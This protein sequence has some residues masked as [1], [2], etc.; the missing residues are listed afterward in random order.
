MATPKKKDRR[1]DNPGRPSTGLDVVTQIRLTP[2]LLDAMRARAERE[3]LTQ[4]EAWRRAATAWL[5]A[6]P[7]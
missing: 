3:G 1:H 2:A 5:A 4:A 6:S 7:R